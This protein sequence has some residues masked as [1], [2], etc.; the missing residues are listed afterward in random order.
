M[1]DQPTPDTVAVQAVPVHQDMGGSFYSLSYLVDAAGNQYAAVANEQLS[2]SNI[3]WAEVHIAPA[4]QGFPQTPAYRVNPTNKIDRVSIFNSGHDLIVSLV[5]HSTSNQYPPGTPRPICIEQ[6][7][8]N[9][10]FA[11]TPD[12]VAQR[13]GEG[14]IIVPA[15]PLPPSGASMAEIQAALDLQ[16]HWIKDQL[17]YVLENNIKPEIVTAVAANL[18]G[19]PGPLANLLYKRIA[20]GVWEQLNKFGDQVGYKP[21]KP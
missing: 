6:A 14:A 16:K 1:A 19:D 8:I 21:P 3:T 5:T 13:G 9:G 11:T 17:A 10:I 12:F 7:R 15:D 18:S 20:D 4:G 2:N